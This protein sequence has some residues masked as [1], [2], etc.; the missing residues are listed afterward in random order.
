MLYIILKPEFYWVTI[1]LWSAAG[2]A[3]VIPSRCAVHVPLIGLINF[4]CEHSSI[5][6][7]SFVRNFP[8]SGTKTSLPQITRLRI[9]AHYTKRQ[10]FSQL[11]F[12]LLFSSMVQHVRRFFHK[13]PVVSIAYR[14]LLFLLLRVAI[15][16]IIACTGMRHVCA[17]HTNGLLALAE[18]SDPLSVSVVAGT[19]IYDTQ[20]H[21]SAPLSFFSNWSDRMIESDGGAGPWNPKMARNVGLLDSHGKCESM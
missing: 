9:R 13:S 3:V 15:T 1:V 2:N 11:D 10:L 8:S 12:H 7:W 18:G 6:Q 20:S 21:W 16:V 4:T 5:P 19:R 14:V 17:F